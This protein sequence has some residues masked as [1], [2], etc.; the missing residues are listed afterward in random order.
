M[1]LSETEAAER[2]RSGIEAF[3]G[4]SQYVA[5]GKK[6]GAGFLAVAKCL[7]DAKAERLTT[8]SMVERYR[9]AA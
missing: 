4:A 5:C 9:K 7:E 8:E 6:R 3:G 1:V 2:Y